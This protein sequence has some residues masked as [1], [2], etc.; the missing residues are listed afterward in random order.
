MI[1][2][3][4]HADGGAWVRKVVL[5][6]CKRRTWKI[7]SFHK[8]VGMLSRPGDLLLD[9]D[10]NTVWSSRSVKGSVDMSSSV[11]TWIF[12]ADWKVFLVVHL[13]VY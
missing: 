10:F 2:P 9:K 7:G 3:F 1:P 6:R 8:I 11:D 13:V 4:S 5:H 12:V